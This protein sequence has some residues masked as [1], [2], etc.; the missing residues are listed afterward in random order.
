SRRGVTLP[1]LCVL[2]GVTWTMGVMG[3]LDE[4][5]SLGTLVLPTLLIVIGSSSARPVGAR[6]YLELE[7]PTGTEHPV[8]RALRQAGLPVF[9]SGLATVIGFSALLLNS[10]RSEER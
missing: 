7:S 2:V 6:Y 10:I 4:P 3:W 5:I 9:I 1:L 8:H